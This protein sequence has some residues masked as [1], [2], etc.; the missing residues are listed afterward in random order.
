MTVISNPPFPTYFDVDGSPLEG[1]YLYF[2]AANQNP[3]T[4]PIAVYWDSSFLIPAAQ[5]IRTSGGFAVRNGT[6]ASIYVTTDYS[7]TVRDKNRRLVYSKLISEGQTTAEVNIQ[8][9]TEA[10]IATSGQTVFNLSTSYTPGNRSLAVYQNGAKL[11]WPQDYT[12]TNGSVV[13]LTIGATVSDVLEFVTA[14]PINPSSLGAAAVAYVPAGTGAVTTNVQE[15]LRQFVSV[16]DFGAVGD[17]VTD[18]TDAVTKAIQTGKDVLVPH[19]YTFCVTGNVTGFVNGQRIYGGGCFKKLGSAIQPL[20]LL[21]DMSDGVW[22]DGIEFDGTKSLFS[23]GNAVP[24]ILGY[25]TYSLAVTNCY[26]HDIIDVGIKLR[27]GANLYASGNR[28]ID[29]SENGIEVHNYTTDVRT[30]S[31]YTGTRPV[32]EGN[33]TIIGNRFERITRYEN[34][35]GPLVDACG[36]LFV[37]TTG[38][39]QKNIRIQGNVIIDCLRGIWTENNVTNSRAENVVISGNTIMGGVNG[40][41]AQN[42]YC[43]AGIGIIAARDVVVSDN[44]IRNPANTNPVGTETAGIIV[45]GAAGVSVCDNVQI[46][47]NHIVDTSGLA[48]RTEWGVYCL[49]GNDIRI[50]ENYV[51]GVTNSAGI[52]LH[53]T[54]VTTAAVYA[55]RGTESEYSWG[56]LTQLTFVRE[57]IP[58]NGNQDTYP[59][60]QL[61]DTEA[62]IPSA[63][64]IVGVSVKLSTAITAGTL[65]VKTYSNGVEQTNVQINNADFSGTVAF[66]KVASASG[67]QVSAGQRFKVVLTTNAA[68]LPITTDA[69]ITVFI[70]CSMKQ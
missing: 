28:F 5:P 25:I 66:K 67:N 49:I 59:F 12:E 46:S 32:I 22:F 17:G 54:N 9:S 36:I 51:S 40:G 30:G 14:T 56:Q 11:V 3:E 44:M 52:Y 48:D 61:F 55:N 20:F 38:Y 24:A 53:P 35:A 58:A 68:F 57:N 63:G 50:H 64:R 2:G 1:G 39:P 69:I 45:S 4:N 27:D 29:I 15:A 47:G 41:T 10:I 70:D 7:I 37:G 60:N 13:T 31:A 19:G 21:P 62:V 18:D 43:K 16:K 42:I 33:H 23:F 26:F 6:P 8:F 34:P 65:S